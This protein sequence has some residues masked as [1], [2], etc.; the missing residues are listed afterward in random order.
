MVTLRIQEQDNTIIDNDLV[1][2]VNA[3]N[4]SMAIRQG[5]RTTS[6]LFTTRHTPIVR[7]RVTLALTD[8]QAII[9]Q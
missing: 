7:F 2:S 4:E 3:H 5:Q 9:V 6:P 8:A 1:K